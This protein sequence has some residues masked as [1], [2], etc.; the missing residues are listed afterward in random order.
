M[1]LGPPAATGW[2]ILRGLRALPEATSSQPAC[3]AGRA[4]GSPSRPPP[5]A[6]ARP[7]S[8]RRGGGNRGTC[9]AA[10]AHERPLQ[11][12]RVAAARPDAGAGRGTPKPTQDP[13]RSLGVGDVGG[14]AA[15][16]SPRSPHWREVRGQ[17]RLLVSS[18]TAAWDPARGSPALRD[19]C[20]FPRC[21]AA[22][23][24][25]LVLSPRVACLP[26]QPSMLLPDL[27]KAAFYDHGARARRHICQF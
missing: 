24:P 21:P 23:T 25:L 15:G 27:N 4:L 19:L 1:C 18:P 7:L 14:G 17:G 16:V 6:P 20:W 5:P 11:P 2:E 3:G 22:G 10:P 26:E 12:G 9:C 13:W 8:P